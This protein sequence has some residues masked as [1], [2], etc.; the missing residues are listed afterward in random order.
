M[1]ILERRRYIF[2][3]L[4]PIMESWGTPKSINRRIGVPRLFVIF[5]QIISLRVEIFMPPRTGIVGIKGRGK[6][7]TAAVSL[8][9]E[10]LRFA[11]IFKRRFHV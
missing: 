3:K 11:A 5:N 7:V 4:G 2:N 1:V 8:G 6:N 9:L 10:R